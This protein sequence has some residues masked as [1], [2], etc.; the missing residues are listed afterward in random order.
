[1]RHVFRNFRQREVGQEGETG[2]QNSAPAA[3]PAPRPDVDRLAGGLA[4]G[5]AAGEDDDLTVYDMDVVDP[6]RFT[7]LLAELLERTL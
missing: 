1:V 3:P 4:D 7:T 6:S 2:C 5:G